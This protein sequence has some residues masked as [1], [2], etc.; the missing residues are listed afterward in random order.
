MYIAAHHIEKE[1]ERERETNK[2]QF[3]FS[4]FPSPLSP[5]S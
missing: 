3:P 4:S 5:S 1:G 2:T